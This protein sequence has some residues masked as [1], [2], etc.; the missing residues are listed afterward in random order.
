MFLTIA[1]RWMILSLAVGNGIACN[2]CLCAIKLLVCL[3][4]MTV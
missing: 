3:F 1:L 2:F 4:L